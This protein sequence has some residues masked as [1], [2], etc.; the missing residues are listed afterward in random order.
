[1]P[2]A[3]AD[4]RHGQK[5]KTREKNRSD[6]HTH[7]HTQT[8][9][10]R[11]MATDKDT[12]PEEITTSNPR[13][14]EEWIETAIQGAAID[15][16]IRDEK[17]QIHKERHNVMACRGRSR[18]RIRRRSFTFPQADRILLISYTVSSSSGMYHKGIISS[19]IEDSASQGLHLTMTS[20]WTSDHFRKNSHVTWFRICHTRMQKKSKATS[21]LILYFHTPLASLPSQTS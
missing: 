9:T 14:T 5:K 3:G 4:R 13:Q 2:Q 1:M 21:H 12:N 19:T 18:I 20:R 15:T 16:W 6:T 17:R 7:T 11:G 10:Q 8:M